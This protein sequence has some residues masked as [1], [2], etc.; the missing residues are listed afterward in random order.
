MVVKDKHSSNPL[1]RFGT[2][3]GRRRQSTHPYGRASSPE[4]KSSTNIGSTFGGFGKGKS[5]DR[6]APG[7][8]D[9][10]SSPLMRLPETPGSPE[11]PESLNHTRVPSTEAPNGTASEIPYETSP[12]VPVNGTVHDSIPELIEPM[13]PP[14]MEE[15]K[16][17]VRR[18]DAS[19]IDHTDVRSPRKMPRVSPYHRQL[20]MQSLKPS[21][22]RGCKC[23]PFCKM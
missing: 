15:P 23:I 6:E 5:K 18:L 7:P 16:P 3:L 19:T 13:A 17:E 12:P 10:P 8:S 2:V 22:R 9:R 20:S 14:P 11:P 1:K 21:A 4:R